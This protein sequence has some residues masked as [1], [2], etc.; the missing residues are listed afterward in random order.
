MIKK[1]AWVPHVKFKA[2]NNGLN[3]ILGIDD[4]LSIKR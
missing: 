3:T 2:K 1:L 4:A